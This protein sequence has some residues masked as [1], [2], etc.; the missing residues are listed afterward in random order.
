MKELLDAQRRQFLAD[1][2]N[3]N[4][5]E[6]VK[7]SKSKLFN[8]FNRMFHNERYHDKVELID[9]LTTQLHNSYLQ[10]ERLKDRNLELANELREYRVEQE[11]FTD[12]KAVSGKRLQ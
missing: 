4:A 12:I 11:K 3:K 1:K 9:E 8:I 2:E 10:A 7:V 5:H 6:H